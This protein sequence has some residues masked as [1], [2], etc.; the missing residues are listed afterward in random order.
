[1]SLSLNEIEKKNFEQVMKFLENTED[2]DLD[3]SSETYLPGQAAYF[4][5]LQLVDVSSSAF[6]LQAK[7]SSEEERLLVL[8]LNAVKPLNEIEWARLNNTRDLLELFQMRTRLGKANNEAIE[9]QNVLNKCIGF[10][11]SAMLAPVSL[12]VAA[13]AGAAVSPIVDFVSK[14]Q[15]ESYRIGPDLLKH[16]KGDLLDLLKEDV[17]IDLSPEALIYILREKLNNNNLTATVKEQLEKLI[18]EKEAQRALNLSNIAL[19]LKQKTAE[20][21]K[22]T[23]EAKKAQEQFMELI[24]VC[25][26][27][28][29]SNEKYV[30][31][32][33]QKK[34][35]LSSATTL[36]NWGQCGLEVSKLAVML[37][38]S[39]KTW[40][41]V[42]N[43]GVT[44]VDISRH[45][46]GFAAASSLISLAS[47]ASGIGVVTGIISMGISL[48]SEGDAA[49]PNQAIYNSV[50]E[51]RR[52]ILNAIGQSHSIIMS[53]LKV[54]FKN[55][56]TLI[57]KN[58]LG[59]SD[60]LRKLDQISM[61]VDRIEKIMV[62][63]I[64]ELHA[65]N[66]Q[67]TL[68]AIY[69][70]LENEK[71]RET[72]DRKKF[73][74]ELSV[75]IDCHSKSPIQ[76]FMLRDDCH[77]S[78]CLEIL[79]SKDF[80]MASTFPFFIAQLSRLL[81]SNQALSNSDFHSLPNVTILST[82][83]KVYARTVMKYNVAENNDIPSL[84]RGIKNLYKVKRI[85]NSIKTN[86][87]IFDDLFRQFNQLRYLVGREINQVLSEKLN[88]DLG[89]ESL[90]TCVINYTKKESITKLLDE[91]ELRRI[92]LSR[93]CEMLGE[94]ENSV[95]LQRVRALE[96]KY[97][98]LSRTK[99]F[100]DMAAKRAITSAAIGQ[101]IDLEAD[102]KNGADVN[103][104]DTDFWPEI[105][106][107]PARPA[108]TWPKIMLTLRNNRL[109]TISLM[110]Q[111][112]IPP[113]PVTWGQPIH[114]ITMQSGSSSI[115]K[116]LA[117]KKMISEWSFGSAARMLH[118]LFKSGIALQQDIATKAD[119]KE[120]WGVNIKPIQI[121]LNNM[122][123]E[124]AILYC[125]NGGDIVETKENFIDGYMKANEN[126]WQAIVQ[127]YLVKDM[128]K[129]DGILHKDKLRMAYKFYRSVEEGRV[130]TQE[131][132]SQDCLLW[133]VAI[134]GDIKPI[135]MF[136]NFNADPNKV[137]PTMLFSPFMMACFCG[138]ENVVDF[139]LKRSV[140]LDAE[141]SV[142]DPHPKTN[143]DD[144][145]VK[146][147]R[148]I[149]R[150]GVKPTALFLSIFSKHWFIANKLIASGF[151]PSAEQEKQVKDGLLTVKPNHNN[152][153]REL[154][155]NLKR[156]FGVSA[157]Y[158]I[159][160]E[161]IED[162]KFARM[163]LILKKHER[164]NEGK[165][166]L[167]KNKEE[168]SKLDKENKD[169]IEKLIRSCNT[170]SDN[171][172][173]RHAALNQ[174]NV[175]TLND[176]LK[177]IEERS[178]IL[179]AECLKSN[180]AA[181]GAMIKSISE[182]L[183]KV[184][185]NL[186]KLSA[187]SKNNSE[188]EKNMQELDEILKNEM[189]DLATAAAAAE[190]AK[191]TAVVKAAAD[192]A[193][194]EKQAREKATLN[195]VIVP[196]KKNFWLAFA[197][198]VASTDFPSSN[199]ISTNVQALPMVFS[200]EA[201]KNGLGKT[202]ATAP[203]VATPVPVVL[204]AINSF[205]QLLAAKRKSIFSS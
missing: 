170:L 126:I 49:D 198:A 124:L 203:P 25:K 93:L 199:G 110:P 44:M 29:T 149:A 119:L 153:Q 81:P 181:R 112:A 106:A 57:L 71:P 111:P 172:P 116:M 129:V 17:G 145:Y 104:A 83:S 166:T 202:V 150:D 201:N 10:G 39:Q 74:S 184:K 15:D 102:L 62:G 48:F 138:N 86:T 103:H 2:E 46:E 69:Y 23:D 135:Q 127:K 41:T 179:L 187:I 107:V 27:D 63:S 160:Q 123:F 204:G 195:Q 115:N 191:K 4:R 52:D 66:L 146:D 188:M 186:V 88:K 162:L 56:E 157:I 164:L 137:I 68:W 178:S 78:K 40:S 87:D 70:D 12:P 161:A 50:Q 155:Q 114:Y 82:V 117:D 26:R 176:I 97:I 16:Y 7:L 95:L 73:L 55:L 79:S 167:V 1:M 21:S 148:F 134:L 20:Y 185:S 133:L 34:L 64:K 90:E 113:I 128:N 96:T 8:S 18:K 125:A 9:K 144:R 152:E 197:S 180:D 85:I 182:Y 13:V 3:F 22:K 194:K 80:D 101:L 30:L 190:A 94:Q 98:I 196:R 169:L 38:G 43:I 193:E 151:K 140:E 75:W 6:K 72:N 51:V 24:A 14:A 183:E 175:M 32:T 120:S 31:N 163:S 200:A 118:L 65:Q 121:I 37:G 173:S 36:K 154:H 192:A 28:A 156:S 76:T 84:I 105:P 11:A 91:L 33:E 141:F 89:K 61:Q 5:A 108:P 189:N 92:M 136:K 45:M 142:I 168:A 60:S 174:M 109:E 53:T 158:A 165:A 131:G 99:E 77:T 19:A 122:R 143:G 159:A 42:G 147:Q 47:I 35:M 132:V 139:L 67:S 58:S 130:I 205:H 177:L 100:Y 171:L 54:S 59:I